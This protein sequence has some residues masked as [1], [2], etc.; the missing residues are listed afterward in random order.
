MAVLPFTSLDADQHAEYL[1]DGVTESIINSLSQLE[2]L[3]VVPRSTV[4][5]YKGRTVNPRSVGLALNVDVIVS[6]RVVQ[7]DKVPNVQAELV[8]VAN[9]TQLW[10]DQY[11]HPVSDLLALQE[12]IA[13]QISEALRVQLTGQEKKR[14]KRKLQERPTDNSDAYHDTSAAATNGQVDSRGIPGSRSTLRGGHRQGQQGRARVFGPGR[15]LWRDGYYGYLPPEIAMTRAS[16]AAYKALELD[17]TLAEAHATMGVT[18]MFFYWDWIGAELALR[19]AVELDPRYPNAHMLLGLLY[20]SW[21]ATTKAWLP[22][23]AAV[24]SI[25]SLVAQMGVTW[26]LYFGGITARPWNRCAK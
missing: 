21:D 15:Y 4:F 19:K 24:S 11:R 8:D 1:A 6:G 22:A 5:A 7:Q 23:G 3:R 17:S 2:K 13:W 16:S 9:E 26:T 14:L 18:R 20:A 10:G 12:Q 25:P